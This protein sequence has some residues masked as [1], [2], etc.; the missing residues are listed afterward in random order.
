MPAYPVLSTG[1]L[2]TFVLTPPC[3]APLLVAPILLSGK[4]KMKVGKSN[5]LVEGDE[6]PLVARAPVA[7]VAGNFISP[8]MGQVEIDFKDEH[9]TKMKC[10]GKKMLR[11]NGKP[12]DVKFKVI[13]PAIDWSTSTPIDD[14]VKEYKGVCTYTTVKGLFFKSE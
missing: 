2:I 10:D 5:V 7:Y 6:V 3:V 12:L 13:T 11:T 14:K 1:D 9:W 8:G 4:G